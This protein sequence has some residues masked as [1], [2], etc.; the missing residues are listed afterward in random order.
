MGGFIECLQHYP[1]YGKTPNKPE[2]RPAQCTAEY[3][4]G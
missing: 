2:E 1:G 4:K 3:A